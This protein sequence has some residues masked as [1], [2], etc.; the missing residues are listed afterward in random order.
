MTLANRSTT[1]QKGM[2]IIGALLVVA[3]ASVATASILERQSYLADTLVG[4]RDR[5]QARWLLRGGID[6]ARILLFADARNNAVTLRSAIWAQPIS[7]FEVRDPASGRTAWFSGMIEDEQ[8]KFN[9]TRLA[10]DGVVQRDEVAALEKLL[11]ALD[12][13]TGLAGAIAHRV[14][15]AQ[16][17]PQGASAPALRTPQDLSGVEGMSPEALAT[18][19][20]YL[21]LLPERTPINVNTAPAEVLS[22][23]I[24]GLSLGQARSLTQ[25]RDRGQWFN[26]RGD[27]LN[28]LAGTR[29][30]VDAPLDVRS[31]WFKVTGQVTLAHAQASMQ[32]LLHRAGDAPPAVRWIED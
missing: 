6:W 26:S 16:A 9:L 15:A 13:P 1:R 23:A 28:R 7:G 27:F 11:G 25:E 21:T 12:T 32:A 30:A 18:L 24:P 14:A 19:A 8:G 22:A 4:E 3:A 29:D 20:T 17:G 5:A 10:V 31:R 2:A